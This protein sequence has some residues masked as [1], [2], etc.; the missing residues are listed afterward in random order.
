MKQSLTLA[1]CV[2]RPAS[3]VLLA[4]AAAVSPSYAA[5]AVGA[6]PLAAPAPEQPLSNPADAE[7]V[8]EPSA[9]V[10]AG[11]PA[12][13]LAST[14]LTLEDLQ[15]QALVNNPAIGR[16]MAL[17]GAARGECVQAG[18]GPNPSVGYEG[19]QLGSGGR[20]EQHGVTFGQEIVT[21]GKLR[22]RRAAASQGVAVA[23]Q[24]LAAVRLRVLTDVR[25][26]YYG[27]LVAQRK[28]R[29]A[30]DLVSLG[31]ELTGAAD[32]LFKAKEVGRVDAIQANLERQQA[33]VAQE[34]VRQRL[35]SAWRELAAVVGDP[36]LTPQ[37]LAGDPLT[38]AARLDFD[39][40]LTRLQ[41]ESPE[42]AAASAELQRA[43]LTVQRERREPIP[44]VTLQGLVNWRD[45]GIGGDPDGGVAVSVPV[46]LFNRNQGA[47]YRAERELAAANQ[48]LLQLELALKQRLAPV[49]ERYAAAQQQTTLY[50][51]TILPQA[52]ESLRL[53]RDMYQAG[54]VNY[55]GLLVAQRTFAVTNQDYLDAVLRLRTAEAEIE[56]LL[57]TGGLTSGR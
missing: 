3:T 24:E 39:S 43:R 38:T 17:V 19:Q 5:E 15:S 9:L 47:I 55:T 10:E 44:N 54:E 2:A 45:N 4:L 26:A 36:S 46:P 48:A 7:L 37:P 40:A 18:L 32:A 12:V 57:L 30:E 27:V 50:R 11:E 1:R 52:E 29:L 31:D 25:V 21:G 22:Y 42:V 8:P 53:T 20:A 49:Y 23:E 28:V 56:G 13:A 35:D 33:S 14:G 51:D 16:A 41:T 34:N 6:E